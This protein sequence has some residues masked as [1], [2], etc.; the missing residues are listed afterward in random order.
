MARELLWVTADGRQYKLQEMETTHL[1]NAIARIRRSVRTDQRGNIV[2]WR[3][4]YLKALVEEIE[5]RG[6]KDDTSLNPARL[7]NRFRN[8][9]LN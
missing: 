8:L 4:H 2:G 1:R 6:L 5:R 7:T 3:L 9:D